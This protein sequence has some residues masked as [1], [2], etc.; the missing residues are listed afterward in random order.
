MSSILASEQRVCPSLAVVGGGLAGIAAA[1]AALQN[2]FRVTLF[3]RSRV[4][5]GRAAS[6]FEP[7]TGQWIDNGQ[8][9]ALGCCTELLD[10]NRQLGL[11]DYFE[12]KESIPFAQIGGKQG[13]LTPVRWLPQCWQFF[14]TFLTFPFLSFRE[15]INTG[16]LLRK[17]STATTGKES[18]PDTFAEWLR[19]KK[20]SANTIEKFWAP[21]IFSALSE[22]VEHVSFEA[23]RQ[24]VRD[25]FLAG[26]RAM[27][28]HIPTLPLRAIYHDIVAEQLQN[29]GIEL[30]F[31]RRVKRLCWEFPADS[32]NSAGNNDNTNT[33]ES[34]PQPS[35]QQHETRL[36][37]D[38]LELSDGTRLSFDYYLLAVPL[39]QFREIM[40]ASDLEPYTEQ[41]DLERFEPGSITTIHLWFNHRLLPD[42][43]SY[44][45]L[46]GGPGQFLFCPQRE[47]KNIP[48][49]KNAGVYHTV[50]ISASHRLLSEHEFTSRGSFGLV[51]RV[52][53]QLQN[54]LAGSF[55]KETTQLLSSRVT[56]HFEAVFS[57]T[58]AVYL[59]RPESETPFEN[60]VLAGDWTQTQLPATLESA[61]RSGR[62][63][64]QILQALLEN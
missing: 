59:Q 58:P 47:R 29:R 13:K 41:L 48:A 42:D 3:E 20:V 44:S 22:S 53:Q 21:L 5:G 23:V 45:V 1:E 17:L 35:P 64:V 10:L 30:H 57:P 62:H 2:G 37:I 46:L 55:H 61:V 27:T 52:V 7:N 49:E 36:R 40:T 32:D 15:R 56:T 4:L 12:R 51:E 50:V 19:T 16:L 11:T 24:I 34:S 8:H 39:S 43:C 14:P 26:Y 18:T 31:L 54:T 25:G 33:A 63:A 60:L 28:F 9:I 38:A 6:L